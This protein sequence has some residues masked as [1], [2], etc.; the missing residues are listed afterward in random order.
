MKAGI[1]EG[2]F[3]MTRNSFEQ[4]HALLGTRMCKPSDFRTIYRVT[5]YKLQTLY[6][7]ANSTISILVPCLHRKQLHRCGKSIRHRSLDCQ[8]MRARGYLR[9]SCSY[10]ESQH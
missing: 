9:N 3:R 10:V 1:F 2:L 5:K 7:F 8:Q 4:L 6:E